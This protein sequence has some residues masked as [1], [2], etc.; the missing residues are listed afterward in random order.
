MS[1]VIGLDLSLTSTG[2]AVIVD[3]ELVEVSTIKS[4]GRRGMTVR[5]TAFRLDQIASDIGVV[6]DHH[7]PDLAVIEAPSFN[8]K[9]GSGHERAG[10]WW[11]VA[12]SL[13]FA[14]GAQVCTV[15]PTTRAKYLSG[16]G[17]AGKDVVLA[18][19]IHTYVK[20]S[21]PRI[22]GDDE[23]DAVGLADMGAR[24]LGE[25]ASGELPEPNM[26]AFAGWVERLPE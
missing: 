23:A 6:I 5:D 12:S 20:P 24:L 9:G 7:L 26:N 3:G 13:M 16:S 18:H 4:K 22:T 1:T 17:R 14:Y 21:G 19:A 2:Y 8:S 15:A 25:P 11:Q 10:L